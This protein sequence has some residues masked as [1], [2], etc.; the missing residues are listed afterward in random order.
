[1]T[2]L[3]DCEQLGNDPKT[4]C[5]A[6]REYI[7]LRAERDAL[8]AALESLLVYEPEHCAC[9]YQACAEPQEAWKKARAALKAR[10]VKP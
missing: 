2:Y 9:G 7:A 4:Y 5:E 6:C 1:M 10:E 3:T 8:K